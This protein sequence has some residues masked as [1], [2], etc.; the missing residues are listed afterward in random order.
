MTKREAAFHWTVNVTEAMSQTKSEMG[1]MGVIGLIAVSY[2]LRVEKECHQALAAIS[3]LLPRKGLFRKTEIRPIKSRKLQARRL[4][5][6]STILACVMFF[7]Q[8]GS[9]EMAGMLILLAGL[10]VDGSTSELSEVIKPIVVKAAKRPRSWSLLAREFPEFCRLI[11]EDDA[12]T[13][14][15]TSD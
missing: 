4:K 1:T 15:R 9:A 7:D 14:G 2:L 3:E 12:G 11:E 13:V 8:V 10:A 5:T 6:I